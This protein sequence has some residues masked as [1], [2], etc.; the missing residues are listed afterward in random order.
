[1]RPSAYTITASGLSDLLIDAER[2]PLTGRQRLNVA[3]TLYANDE[4]FSRERALD[5]Y[6]E[7]RPAYWS[8]ASYHSQVACQ[9]LDAANLMS[10]L[11]AA[12]GII[13]AHKRRNIEGYLDTLVPLNRA[14]A[15]EL[16]RA[17]SAHT[18]S[19]RDEPELEARRVRDRAAL[20]EAST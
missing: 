10:P 4:A 16:S 19:W 14:A 18:G 20:T 5:A 6:I 13:P 2:N 9:L 15:V 11:D 3:I 12:L 1:M 17:Y 8:T 7:G